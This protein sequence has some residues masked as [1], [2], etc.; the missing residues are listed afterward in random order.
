MIWFLKPLYASIKNAIKPCTALTRR[1]EI[2]VHADLPRDCFEK[3]M[4]PL[5]EDD[6]SDLKRDPATGW[7]IP[8]QTTAALRRFEYTIKRGS[9]GRC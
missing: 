4:S 6:A 9:P 5:T 3:F 8:T 1:K 2:Q 7:L